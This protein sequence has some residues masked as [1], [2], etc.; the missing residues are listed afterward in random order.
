M[1]LNR[2]RPWI[3]IH[4]LGKFVLGTPFQ[5]MGH[6]DDVGATWE[7]IWCKS[8]KYVYL[9]DAT[10]LKIYSDSAQD[11]QN[12]TGARTVYIEGLDADYNAISETLSLHPTDGT[13]P[14][15][16]IKSYLRVF[17]MIVIVSG[18]NN[19]NVGNI[20]VENF[21]GTVTLSYMEIDEGRCLA[22]I[23]TIPNGKTASILRWAYNELQAKISAI[24]LFVRPFEQSW[25][26]AKLKYVKDTAQDSLFTMPIECMAKSDIEIRA[27]ATGGAGQVSATF[28]GYYL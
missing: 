4:S 28:E 24:A 18:T 23:Y 26:I 22:C 14:V 16:S 25:Y 10:R 8:T 17:C 1:T 9:S 21:A 7:T 6:N 19:T 12:G 11:A 3:Y 2:V 15:F 5:R 13:T 20:T 27:W